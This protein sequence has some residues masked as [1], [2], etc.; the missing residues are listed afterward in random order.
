MPVFK[1][2]FKSGNI[3]TKLLVC[4][5]P[6]V[7]L[8]LAITG[9][10]TYR[11]TYHFINIA[12]ERIIKVQTLAFTHEVEKFLEKCKQDLIQRLA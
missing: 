3:K 7:V 5:I 1:N 2:G 11:I 6:P 9:Y 8:I 4:I 12:L 10:I